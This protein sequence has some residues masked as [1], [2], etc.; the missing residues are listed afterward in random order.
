MKLLVT[1]AT[2]FLG[3]AVVRRLL[4][5]GHGVRALARPDSPRA[6][7]LHPSVE[8]VTGDLTDPPSLERAVAGVEGVFHVAAVYSYWHRDPSEIYRVNVDGTEAL[9]TAAKRAG[10]RRAVFTSTVATLRWPGKGILADESSVASLDDLPGHYKKSKLMAEQAAMALNGGGFEVVVVNPTAPFGPGDSRPTPTGRIVLEFLNKRFP[11][12]VA[13][14]VN[15]CDVD[16]AA[17]GH[18]LAFERGRPGERYILGGTGNMSLRQIYET[19]A[20]VTGLRRRPV[21][22]PFALAF[23]AGWVD[24]LVEAKLLRREPFVPLEGLR[25]A[26][27]PLYV[28]CQKA[29]AELGL[30]QRPP[31]ESLIRSARW[32]D[33][34]GYSRAKMPAISAESRRGDGEVGR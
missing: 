15:V 7:S 31:A 29:V 9:L 34:N 28:T 19:L 23:A 1:G 8:V 17:E 25:V 18:A 10:A 26:R 3:G 33:A 24:T 20:N 5:R 16:D 13:T 27:H 11:G 32:F 21:R 22:V 12:Y 2:G 30:P 14:G 4:A 6:A